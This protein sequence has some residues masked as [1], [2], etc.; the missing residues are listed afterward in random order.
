MIFEPKSWAKLVSTI[1]IEAQG[2]LKFTWA[3]MFTVTSNY[4]KIIMIK[5]T[6]I[7]HLVIVARDEFVSEY[8]VPR[9]ILSTRDYYSVPGII[10]NSRRFLP[11]YSH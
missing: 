5:F 6:F 9:I 10:R 8:S 1:N 3:A 4:L 2:Y 7:K 11:P